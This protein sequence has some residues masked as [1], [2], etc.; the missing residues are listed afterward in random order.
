ML[1][2]KQYTNRKG[3]IYPTHGLGPV[4]QIMDINRGDKLDYLVS[5]ESNDFMMGKRAKELASNR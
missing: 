1:W 5:V 3:N 4:S 2:L